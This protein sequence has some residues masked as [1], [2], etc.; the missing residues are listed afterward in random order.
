VSSCP[1]AVVDAPVETVWGLLTDPAGWSSVYDLRVIRVEPPGPARAG[2][3]V[4]GESGPRWL[5]LPVTLTFTDID[6]AERR[7]ALD[8]QMP[9]RLAVREELSCAPLNERQ[10]RVNFHCHF[11]VPTGWRGALVS[12]LLR[13]ELRVGPADSLRRLKAAAERTSSRAHS[14]SGS[15]DR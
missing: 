8:V 9:L 4:F 1:T 2:Q 5:H 14:G 3:R 11:G 7:L 12:A 6:V 13:R 15:S 10:C